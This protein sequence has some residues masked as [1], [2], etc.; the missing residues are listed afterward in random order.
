MKAFAWILAAMAIFA[1][2]AIRSQNASKQA[3]VAGEEQ[4]RSAADAAEHQ[5]KLASLQSRIDNVQAQMDEE[6]GLLAERQDHVAVA[7]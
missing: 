2:F 4:Q 5:K 3:S 1:V 6:K 7:R